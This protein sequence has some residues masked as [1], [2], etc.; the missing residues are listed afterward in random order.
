MD[1]LLDTLK[2]AL[3]TGLADGT[4]AEI[5]ARFGKLELDWREDLEPGQG[6]GTYVERVLAAI[7]QDQ[8]PA[9]AKRGLAHF[10]DS[11]QL[12][13]QDALWDL[14]AKGV[15]RVSPITRQGIADALDGRR[16][17]PD[18]APVK[19]LSKLALPTSTSYA[20]RYGSSGSLE[21][22]DDPLYLTDF[23]SPERAGRWVPSSHRDLFETFGYERWPDQRLFRV[24]EHLVHPMIRKDREQSEWVC[25]FNGLLETDGFKLEES[26][27]MSGHPVFSVRATHPDRRDRPKNI[28]FAA[29]GPKP[30]L[31]F[32]DALDNDIVILQNAEHCLVY[33]ERI[34]DEGLTW[35]A[36]AEWW[37]AGSTT[38]EG[39]PTTLGP[40]PRPTRRPPGAAASCSSPDTRST[41]LGLGS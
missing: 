41:A 33:D 38:R 4:W 6:K 40:A 39:R 22:Y 26:D 13:V 25:M 5:K 1:P 24:L 11:K 17:A 35:A 37:K 12:A 30:E 32:S 10:K 36:L 16:L 28:I 3:V 8:W 9:I 19:L 7:P 31:G 23:G 27:E 18:I 2:R 21:R 34:G 15:R 14:E 29:K 20:F